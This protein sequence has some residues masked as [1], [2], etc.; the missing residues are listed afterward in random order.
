M[1]DQIIL[2][3]RENFDHLIFVRQKRA[4]EDGSVV[5]TNVIKK[6]YD[7]LGRWHGH[8][9]ITLIDKEDWEDIKDYPQIKSG[10]DRRIMD[11]LDEIPN[12]FWD[13]QE[14]AAKTRQKVAEKEDQIRLKDIVISDKDREIEE[15]KRKLEDNG[16]R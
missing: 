1:A 9:N 7:I 16:I 4:L 5:V 3:S 10:L 15:L 6:E 8:K 2:R 13:A 11:I 12:T 14:M